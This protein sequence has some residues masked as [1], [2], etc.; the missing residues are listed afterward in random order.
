LT[1]LHAAPSKL[2]MLGLTALAIA[3]ASPA[4]AQLIFVR[5]MYA[6]PPY[7]PYYAPALPPA[8]IAALVRRAG[9]IP[10]GAPIRRGR[11]YII[12]ASSRMGEVSLV[13]NAR[14]GRILAVRPALHG[15]PAPAEVVESPGTHGGSNAAA[16]VPSNA[17][18]STARE[19]ETIIYRPTG[20]EP[21]PV[22][23]GLSRDVPPSRVANAPE[24]P[25]AA[26]IP[27]KP[28]MPK[29]RLNPPPTGEAR[30]AAAT[31]EQKSQ[32]TPPGGEVTGAKEPDKSVA[33]PSVPVAPLE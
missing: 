10:L 22:L 26:T 5:S 14:A 25:K 4:S 15:A 2:M 16:A 17:R 19:Q 8:Q 3:A 27:A 23:P 6:G 32:S 20:T 11:N 33:A 7:A 29:P 9:F 18:Q 30:A 31:S 1:P 21:W 28:P 24:G 12:M 13:V